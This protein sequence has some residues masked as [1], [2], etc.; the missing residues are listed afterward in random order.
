MYCGHAD[1]DERTYADKQLGMHIPQTSVF[2]ELL[3]HVL[4]S[5]PRSSLSIREAPRLR[6]R[7][8]VCNH[9]SSKRLSPSVH[10]STADMPAARFDLSL[11]GEYMYR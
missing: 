8:P 1:G 2:N 6:V 3:Q 7:I 11:C 5:F 9:I 4:Y 10:L